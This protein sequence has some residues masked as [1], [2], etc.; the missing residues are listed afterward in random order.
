MSFQDQQPHL[1]GKPFFLFLF[2]LIF[3]FFLAAL[4]GVWD[5]EFPARMKLSPPSYV[6]VWNHNHWFCPGGSPEAVLTWILASFQ[7]KAS[8]PG[9][10][11]V[12]Q[13]FVEQLLNIVPG[14]TV[15]LIWFG[16]N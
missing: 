5:L 3:N 10:V 12:S 4:H 14:P 1:G 7:A 16:S 9:P 6:E 2:K 8:C 13:Y 15:S 11:G